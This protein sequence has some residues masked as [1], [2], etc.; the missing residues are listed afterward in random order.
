MAVFKSNQINS[1]PRTW[2]QF[3]YRIARLVRERFLSWLFS[4]WCCRQVSM[5][6]KRQS[7]WSRLRT[8]FARCCGGG[9]VAC[10]LCSKAGISMHRSSSVGFPTARGKTVIRFLWEK[11]V[12]WLLSCGFARFTRGGRHAWHSFLWLSKPLISIIRKSI[13]FVP[14]GTW[15]RLI[16]S[17]FACAS[18]LNCYFPFHYTMQLNLCIHNSTCCFLF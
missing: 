2:L 12:K 18:C 7:M 5:I 1:P 17:T 11:H 13:R 16:C 9:V 10:V 15:N 3:G 14:L 8:C 4:C 6:I